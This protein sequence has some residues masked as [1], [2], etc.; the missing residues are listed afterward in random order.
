MTSVIEQFFGDGNAISPASLP[1]E[2]RAA[3]DPWVARFESREGSAFLPR[4][5]DGTLRWYGLTPGGNARREMEGLLIQWLGASFTDMEANRGVLDPDDPFDAWLEDELPGRVV[6]FEVLPRGDSTHRETV[7]SRLSSLVDL[8]DGRPD[9]PA[10]SSFRLRALIEDMHKAAGRG[11]RDA[12]AAVLGVIRDRRLVDEANL[13][14]LRVEMLHRLHAWDELLAPTMLDR[15]ERMRVPPGVVRAIDDA[16]YQ[17]DLAEHD[18]AGDVDALMRLRDQIPPEVPGIAIQGGAPAGRADLIVQALLLGDRPLTVERLLNSTDDAIVIEILGHGDAAGGAGSAS[19]P[20]APTVP[21]LGQLYSAA[22]QHDHAGVLTIAERLPGPIDPFAAQTVLQAAHTLGD[23]GAATRAL[24]VT[25]RDLGPLGNVQWTHVSIASIVED[26]Q[27]RA[28]GGAPTSWAAWLRLAADG[29]ERAQTYEPSGDWAAADPEQVLEIVPGIEPGLLASV[30]GQL[31]SAHRDL[32]TGEQRADLGL[33]CLL[34][35]SI[36]ESRREPDRLAASEMLEDVLDGGGVVPLEDVVDVLE[37]LVHAHMGPSSAE[38]AIDVLG[39]VVEVAVGDDRALAARL[40]TRIVDELRTC[41]SSVN[42][43]LYEALLDS[44]TACG[45][46]IP[47]DLKHSAAAEEP[48]PYEHLRGKRILIYSLMERPARRAAA[49]LRALGGGTQVHV[50]NDHGGS[51][52]LG[53]IAQNVDIA[54]IVTVAAKHAAT[55]FIRAQRAPFPCLDINALGTTAILRR[56]A[57]DG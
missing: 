33:T 11:Q 12:A 19:A 4:A 21:D 32:L 45:T 24:A 46:D 25:S 17:R 40:T 3:L 9:R 55:D 20:E 41:W 28:T 34:A 31:R 37:D 13:L 6:R 48:L 18:E 27:A 49:I 30:V 26:L 29:D 7:R 54:A 14:F 57:R 35:L 42:R 1:T 2:F 38:W 43:G 16:V 53:S 8:V 51:D 15:L 22:G 23:K 44:A 10:F 52:R 56:L 5:H 39:E 36:S 50:A 47:A